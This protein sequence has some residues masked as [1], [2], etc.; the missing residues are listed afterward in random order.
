M[1]SAAPEELA[2]AIIECVDAGAHVLNL[3]VD[4]LHPSSKG[5]LKLEQALDYAARYGVIT[6]AAAGN[7]GTIGTSTLTRHTWT[8]PVV[9]CDL[10]SRPINQSNL[11]ISIGRRGLR[12]PGEAITSLGVEEGKPLK[13]TGTSAAAPF[14]SGTIALLWSEFPTATAIEVKFAVT[15]A[16]GQRR[17][18][19][20]PPLLDARAAYQVMMKTRA[21]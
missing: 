17:T 18:T 1:P 19:I 15:K 12:A 8:I 10:Q 11:G 20:V 9:A 4:L 16:S 3:S 5:E 2:T 13:L 6:V 21:P 14:V 7:Q